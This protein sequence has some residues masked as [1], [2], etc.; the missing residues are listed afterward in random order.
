MQCPKEYRI[1]YVALKDVSYR[2]ADPAAKGT[3]AIEGM[4]HEGR[5]LLLEKPIAQEQSGFEVKAYVEGAG[6]VLV[7]G[8]SLKRC[9]S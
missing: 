7:N 9:S 2:S 1:E 6:L 8:G 5:V 4:F 3:H